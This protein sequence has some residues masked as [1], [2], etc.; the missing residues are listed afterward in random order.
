MQ[1]EGKYALVTGAS[2]GIGKAIAIELMRRS[3]KVAVGYQ[4]EEHRA[5]SVAEQDPYGGSFAVR[6]NVQDRASIRKAK[7]VLE[8]RFGAL[9]IIVNNAGINRPNDFDKI[10]D[11]D[12]DAILGTNLAGPFKVVQ[13]HLPLLRDG[14]A[15]VNISSVSGQYGGPRTTHYAVSKAG[16]ISLTQNLAIFCAPKKIR[17]NAVSPGLI[18]SEMAK[19]ATNLPVAEK[20]LL[21]RMGTPEEVATTVAFLVSDDASYITAQTINVNGGLY[22]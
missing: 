5:Q 12:W 1:L 16:L 19:A 15:I 7:A 14:G 11:Q 4:G 10:T 3:A 18:E 8:D 2:R 13:E 21:K 9:D 6:I 17:V 20:I 22:F